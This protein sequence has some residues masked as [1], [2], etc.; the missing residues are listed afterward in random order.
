MENK[1]LL[2]WMVNHSFGL[3]RNTSQAAVLLLV[4]A[5]VLMGLSFKNM[6]SDAVI[7]NDNPH[8]AP[9]R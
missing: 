8:P 4:V 6:K 9:R 5:V 1:G 2:T 3:L 7:P